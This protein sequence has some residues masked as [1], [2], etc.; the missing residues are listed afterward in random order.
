MNDHAEKPARMKYT[1]SSADMHL[2]QKFTQTATNKQAKVK[3]EESLEASST[4]LLN[5]SRRRC[6][7]PAA[8]PSFALTK[9]Y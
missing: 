4:Q 1:N 9:N 3:R 5:F 6:V 8:V 7:I 2:N